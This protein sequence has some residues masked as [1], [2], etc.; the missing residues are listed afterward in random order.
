LWFYFLY[1]LK[2]YPKN[3]I[4][5]KIKIKI[6]RIKNSCQLGCT[7][8]YWTNHNVIYIAFMGIN[9]CVC[10]WNICMQKSWQQTTYYLPTTFLFNYLPGTYYLL[11]QLLYKDWGTVLVVMHLVPEVAPPQTMAFR[12][13]GSVGRKMALIIPTAAAAAA[14][15]PMLCQSS[16]P[17]SAL[18]EPSPPP[19]SPSTH[20]SFPPSTNHFVWCLWQV[21]CSPSSTHSFHLSPLALF[22]WHIMSLPNFWICEKM[23]WSSCMVL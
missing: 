11:Q 21:S 6:C 14:L 22:V 10:N 13:V 5:I 3:K 20:Y 15:L 19:P 4:K 12:M 2:Y 17:S 18:S 16:A 8:A 1:F 9:L 7:K 23:L